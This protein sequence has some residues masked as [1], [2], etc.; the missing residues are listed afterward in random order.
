MSL[1]VQRQHSLLAPSAHYSS[2]VGYPVVFTI[3]V[4][5][6]KVIITP[7]LGNLDNIVE[8]GQRCI[9]SNSELPPDHWTDATNSHLNRVHFHSQAVAGK[10]CWLFYRQQGHLMMIAPHFFMLSNTE[11]SLHV[12]AYNLKRMMSILGNEGLAIKLREQYN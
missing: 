9:S 11:I 2:F 4:E 8:S 5:L 10:L 1:I 12:L 3:N 6:V 7:A